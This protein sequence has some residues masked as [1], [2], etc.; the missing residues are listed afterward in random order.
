MQFLEVLHSYKDI[1][2][3]FNN[4]TD[5]WKRLFSQ[6]TDKDNSILVM[7]NYIS[8]QVKEQMLQAQ[9]LLIA[10]IFDFTED[11]F[12]R[13]ILKHSF[14]NQIFINSSFFLKISTRDSFVH[15]YS[16]FIDISLQRYYDLYSRVRLSS[17]QNILYLKGRQEE[18]KEG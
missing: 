12:W 11:C 7:L 3:L 2:I 5:L 13:H 10:F 1:C 17:S 9:F 18:L 16:I 15:G 14:Y 8:Q 6:F 4:Y